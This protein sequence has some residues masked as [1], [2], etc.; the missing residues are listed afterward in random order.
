MDEKKVILIASSSE[1][2]IEYFTILIQ[3]H[4]S[5]CT[6]YSSK[7]SADA[8]FKIDNAPPNILIIDNEL[9][10]GTSLDMAAKVL[11]QKNSKL[12][13]LI[14]VNP[15]PDR[16][17]FIDEV[18]L[19][20]VQFLTQPESEIHF[21]D[22]LCRSLNYVG[23]ADKNSTYSLR[24]ILAG[25]L[26][27]SEGDAADCAFV[28]RKGQMKAFKV[29]G[30]DQIELGDILEGEFVGEMAHINGGSRSATVKASLDCELIEIPFVT[31]DA[32]LFSKP[33]WSKALVVTLSK[34]LKN[35]NQVLV[36]D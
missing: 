2:N 14:I 21:S 17:H 18:V 13:A 1:S 19:G 28:L 15:I 24:F 30:T 27:F 23:R 26:L 32:V 6:I 36:E 7:D 33:A 9:A 5:N 12:M 35:T 25:Q 20:K 4:L 8:L 3:R 11:T 16:E 31:L 10:K 29:S 22:A 34:R